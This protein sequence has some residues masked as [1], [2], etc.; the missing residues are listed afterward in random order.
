ME[1]SLEGNGETV[2]YEE[3]ENS[4]N[5]TQNMSTFIHP[6]PLTFHSQV[7]HNPRNLINF[8]KS[9]QKSPNKSNS[10]VYD[11]EA[12]AEIEKLRRELVSKEM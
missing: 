5:R 8:S 4:Q 9:R 11:P 6:N 3:H 1:A 10:R 7:Q 2:N 12:S